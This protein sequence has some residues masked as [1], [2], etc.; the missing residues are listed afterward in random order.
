MFKYIP[1]NQQ[2]AKLVKNNVQDNMWI[3]ANLDYIAI[4][5]DVDIPEGDEDNEQD[6]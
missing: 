4:M 2:V 3:K 5:C 6:R 1:L